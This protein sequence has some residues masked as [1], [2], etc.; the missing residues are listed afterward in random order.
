[1]KGSI[2][3]LKKERRGAS[4]AKIEM[5]ERKGRRERAESE[6]VVD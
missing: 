3:R 1:M 4:A 5:R 2:C 6:R